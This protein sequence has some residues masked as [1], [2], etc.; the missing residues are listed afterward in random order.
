MASI[1]GSQTRHWNFKSV[2]G[3][4]SRKPSLISNLQLG[5]VKTLGQQ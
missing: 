4:F 3:Y 1:A 5:E 2:T